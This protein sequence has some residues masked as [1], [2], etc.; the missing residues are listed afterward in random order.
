MFGRELRGAPSARWPAHRPA[1]ASSWSRWSARCRCRRPPRPGAAPAPHRTGAASVLSRAAGNPDQRDA[2]AAGIGDQI[3][4][5]RRFAGVRQHQ[6]HVALRHHAQ[7]AMAGLCRDARNAQACRCWPASPR[8]CARYG[9]ICP[10][11]DTITRP[12]A[13]S[14]TST[15]VAKLS[16]S[17]S[18]SSDNACASRGITRRPVARKTICPCVSA[19][20]QSSGR[21]CRFQA[22]RRD[23]AER[24]SAGSRNRPAPD[25]CGLRASSRSFSS[26]RSWCRYS[27]SDAA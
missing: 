6:H 21:R 1:P 17:A 12:A 13:A 18:A 5:F 19:S 25:R 11:R 9:P 8:S 23:P 7:I 3:G 15:A 16:S 27:T 4:Q 24:A 14:I 20:P 2:E 22:T 10:C 26:S